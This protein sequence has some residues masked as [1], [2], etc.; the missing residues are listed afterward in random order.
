MSQVTASKRMPP[1]KAA[2]PMAWAPW[3]D[4]KGRFDRTRAITFG[5]LLLPIAALA[6]RATAGVLGARPLNAAI[7]STGF[8]AVVCLVASLM[9]SP[10]KAIF[11]LPHIVV[12]RRMIGNAALAYALLH[13]LLYCADQNWHALTIVA[14]IAK[15]F[16]LTV[17]L[18]ALIGLAVLGATS[19]DGAIRRMGARWKRLHKLAYGI[20]ALTL[21]HFTLQTKADVSVPLLF[22]GVFIWLMVWRQM[23]VGRDR[24][25]GGLLVIGVAAA[26]LTLVTEYLWYRFGT[27]I[28]PAKILLAETDVTFGFGP[29]DMVLLSGLLAA[30]GLGL[31]RASQGSWGDRAAF[32]V[33][34]FASGALFNEL[35]VVVFGIDRFLEPG[36]WSFLWQ[37]LAWAALLGVLG[38]LHWRRRGSGQVLEVDA[39]ALCCIAYQVTRLLS[40]TVAPELVL[41]AAIV[42]L[43]AVLAW[44]TWRETKLAAL[45]LLPLAALLVYGVT[46]PV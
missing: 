12:L 10:A 30:A 4:K 42:G 35:I 28:D 29:T 26:A 15:R 8:W 2:G 34:L 14:E 11:N 18:V 22:V 31:R 40:L 3:T 33:V 27:R 17:G 43:W 23:P 20:A 5:L 1:A 6:I 16:Y 32:W 37:D 21:F 7:H 38:F 45:G 36:D 13:L 39:L 41:A 25:I 9:V 24:S 44:Q 46:A 19:T